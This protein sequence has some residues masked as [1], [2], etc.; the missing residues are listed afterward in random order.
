MNSVPQECEFIKK[1]SALV[2]RS[3]CPL[4]SDV[5]VIP[6]YWCMI[7]EHARIPC[8]FE[9]RYCK[10]KEESEEFAEMLEYAE[11]GVDE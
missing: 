1:S 3:E 8:P 9:N 5:V 4:V 6:Y 11:G 2:E 7:E 10:Y